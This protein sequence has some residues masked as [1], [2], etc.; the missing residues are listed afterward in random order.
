MALAVKNLPANAGDIRDTGSISGWEDP[1]ETEMATHSSI[2]AW[3]IPWTEEPGGLQSLGSQRVGRSWKQLSTSTM[4]CM[5]D[6]Y[7][8]MEWYHYYPHFTDEET[9]IKWLVQSHLTSQWLEPGFKPRQVVL[10]TTSS[11]PLGH[12]ATSA[13]A[14]MLALHKTVCSCT[15]P[16]GSA[17]TELIFNNTSYKGL[18]NNYSCCGI[19]SYKDCLK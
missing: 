10:W 3:R 6:C 11:Q 1:L 17:R 19:W 13:R 12:A 14:E 5:F 2:L 16:M 8:S 15:E 9:F 18:S 7:K 4:Y